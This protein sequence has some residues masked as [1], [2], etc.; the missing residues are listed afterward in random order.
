MKTENKRVNSLDEKNYAL[1]FSPFSYIWKHK[2]AEIQIA[3]MI[4]E[5]GF[6]IR[7]I[8]CDRAFSEFCTSMSA[9]KT[10]I[11]DEPAKKQ[12]ICKE[13]IKN[14][15]L[16]KLSAGR[17]FS[18]QEISYKQN[19]EYLSSER[20]INSLIETEIDDVPIGRLALYETLL[21]YKKSNLN[22]TPEQHFHYVTHFNNAVTTY[23]AT[24]EIIDQEKPDVVF[25][26]SPQYVVPGIASAYAIKQG[27]KVFFMEGSS[28]DVERYTHMRIWN[29]EKY[30]LSQPGLENLDAFADYIPTQKQ[31]NRAKKQIKAKK[32]KKTLS[33]YSPDSKGIDPF[34][35][36]NLDRKKP[37]LL[38]AMSSYDEVYSGYMIGKLPKARFEGKVFKD[39]VEWLKHTIAWVEC[40]DIQLIIRPHPREFPNKR[41]DV[42]SD[43]EDVWN[44]ILSNLPKNVVIDHPKMNYSIHDYLPYIDVFTTGWSST[45]IEAL[46]NGIPVVTYDDDLPTIPRSIL[47]SGKSQE[48]YFENLSHALGLGRSE[49]RAASAL[50]WLAYANEYGT[51]LHGG[52]LAARLHLSDKGIIYKALNSGY[53]ENLTKRIDL[54]LPVPKR[55]RYKLA[56]MAFGQKDSLFQVIRKE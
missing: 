55:E 32:S 26:Y 51:M 50:K 5:F 31:L 7:M 28:N 10:G 14:K 53:L 43:H 46:A 18:T 20:E 19:S 30:G 16:S 56:Q 35:F 41:E 8:E 3:R 45:A 17:T 4:E 1:I 33:V 49:Q 47:I 36:F 38:L 52:S 29:W 40:K 22:F 27:I 15:N 25:C 24:K 12:S 23:Y 21:H 6:K 54:L 48:G 2:L 42:K 11:F 9:A 13:C 34:S 44:D 39:Q 37:I